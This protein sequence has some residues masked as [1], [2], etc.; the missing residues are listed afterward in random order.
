[1][2]WAGV[3]ALVVAL[4]TITGCVENRKAEAVKPPPPKVF[5]GKATQAEV[6]DYEEFIGRTAAVESVQ[7]QARVSGELTGIYFKDG[8]EVKKDSLLFS[9]D[10][11]PFV[12]DREKAKAE[13]DRSKASLA[14]KQSK[15]DRNKTLRQTRAISEEEWSRIE[16]DRDEA[17]ALVASNK[18]TLDRQ[19]LNVEWC[20]VKAP[21]DGRASRTK[22][23]VGNQVRADT[24][25]LT[26]VVSQDPIYVYI[27]CDERAYLRIQTLIRQGLL[28]S[29]LETKKPMYIGLANET[30]TAHE[31]FIDF[32]DNEINPTT[33]TLTVRGRFDNPIPKLASKE[34]ASVQVKSP[35][36][37]LTPGLFVNVRVPVSQPTKR[38]LIPDRIIATVRGKR[39][40]Y[41]VSNDNKVVEHE[42]TLGQ[43][44]QGLRTLTNVQPPLTMDTMLIFS[45]L[46]RIQPGAVVEPEA[47]KPNTPTASK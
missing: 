38:W 10:E 11:R 2:R 26:T 33:G 6:R 18:A 22:L 3:L 1:M 16:A 14:D 28:E 40:I 30:T 27:D 41:S 8:D 31:G 39:Y 19:V 17:I 24:T 23:T 7:L 20:K 43:T 4:W 29:A 25:L 32:V 15:Y 12:A 45:G 13:Y 46:Q 35:P 47:T 42:I 37:L 9:I 36:R 44:H 5:T 34:P 21:I